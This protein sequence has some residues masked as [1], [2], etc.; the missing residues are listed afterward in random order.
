MHPDQPQFFIKE[1]SSRGPWAGT[2]CVMNLVAGRTK[3][4]SGAKPNL[5]WAC[6]WM[7]NNAYGLASG[8]LD[9]FA[10]R[11][12]GP[13]RYRFTKSQEC[14]VKCGIRKRDFRIEFDTSDWSERTRWIVTIV[15]L[16]RTLA[17]RLAVKNTVMA[18]QDESRR[19]KET[20]SK[21]STTKNDSADCARKSHHSLDD[22]HGHTVNARSNDGHGEDR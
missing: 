9:T 17:R 13:I 3:N 1:R 14:A 5:L 4:H 12:E 18:H 20:G 10:Q 16:D 21:S 15:E 7:M 22:P 8:S 2:G 6:I 11:N 19:D